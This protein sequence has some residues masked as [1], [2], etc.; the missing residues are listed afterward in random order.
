MAWLTSIKSALLNRRSFMV[1]LIAIGVFVAAMFVL[2]SG[3]MPY[4]FCK[5]CT[6]DENVLFSALSVIAAMS[7]GFSAFWLMV[8][9]HH[10]SL[11]G[12]TPFSYIK[13]KRARSRGI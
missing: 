8:V 5:T 1:Q 9:E 13:E 10:R 11:H 3:F 4:G 7:L 6:T 12:S 2:V